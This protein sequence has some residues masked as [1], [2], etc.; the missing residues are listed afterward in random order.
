MDQQ[1]PVDQKQGVLGEN[2]RVRNQVRDL[3]LFSFLP[4]LFVHFQYSTV[5]WAFVFFILFV[6]F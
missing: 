5:N 2:F 1:V 4:F 6:N 3:D